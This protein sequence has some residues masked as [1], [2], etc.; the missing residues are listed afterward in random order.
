M[1][2]MR[3]LALYDVYYCLIRSLTRIIEMPKEIT[4]VEIIELAEEDVSNMFAPVSGVLGAVSLSDVS[5]SG[6]A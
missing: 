6:S 3:F 1:R 4:S 2:L 5:D